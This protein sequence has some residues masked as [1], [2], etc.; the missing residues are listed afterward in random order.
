MKGK[1]AKMSVQAVE[2]EDLSE[3]MPAD[4]PLLDANMD[5]VKDVK[6]E[7]EAVLGEGQL[8][9]GE[10]FDLCKGSILKLNRDV[11]EPIEVCL[12][13]RVIARGILVAVDDNFG[14]RITEICINKEK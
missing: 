12:D 6:V 13:G 3:E 5:L 1:N 4:N 7:L 8:T 2:L 14:V 9:V 10:L 11:A